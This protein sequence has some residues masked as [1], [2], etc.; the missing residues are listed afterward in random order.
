MTHKRPPGSKKTMDEILLN[1]P[2]KKSTLGDF[3]PHDFEDLEEFGY[4]ADKIPPM[5]RQPPMGK[6]HKYVLEGARQSH[7]K[8]MQ[9]DGLPVQNSTPFK[10]LKG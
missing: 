10:N 2:K 5:R 9:P 4:E 7:G 3:L 6:R 8:P 1:P